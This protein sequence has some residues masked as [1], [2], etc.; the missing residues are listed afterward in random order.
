MTDTPVLKAVESESEA[1]S[2]IPDSSSAVFEVFFFFET[3]SNKMTY[4]LRKLG[5]NQV[6]QIESIELN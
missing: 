5:L 3:S 4:A 2:D 6:L 1:L